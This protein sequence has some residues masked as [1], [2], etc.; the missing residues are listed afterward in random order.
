LM[1]DRGWGMGKGL[2]M[3]MENGVEKVEWK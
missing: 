1:G 3:R 2:G